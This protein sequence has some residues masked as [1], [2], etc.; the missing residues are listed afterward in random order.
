MAPG[1]ALEEVE[2]RTRAG[3]SRLGEPDL[4]GR[5]SAERSQGPLESSVDAARE[6]ARSD[7]PANSPR[8]NGAP[9]IHLPR[10]ASE[11]P[12][13]ETASAAAAARSG[14]AGDSHGLLI[15]PS[16]DPIDEHS[17][18]EGEPIGPRATRR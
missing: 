1:E 5:P 10:R 17:P 11:G 6:E 14:A 9:D 16:S 18:A 2:G 3:R 15:A 12:S 13:L 8:P 4:L 7:L